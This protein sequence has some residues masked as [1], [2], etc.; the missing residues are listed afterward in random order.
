MK[1]IKANKADFLLTQLPQTRKDQFFFILKNRFWSIFLIGLLL[2]ISLLPIIVTVYFRN[3]F[4]VGFYSLFTS[5]EID[6]AEYDSSIFY[7]ILYSS[8]ICTVLLAV[9]AICLSGANRIFKQIVLGE[10]MIFW[11][12]FKIGIKQNYLNTFLILLFFGI[13]MTLVRFLST[14]FVQYFIGI[15]LYILL[16]IL[17]VPTFIVALIFTS[18]YEANVFQC[19]F[20]AV[21]LYIPYWWK[22]LL[23]SL[24]IM[25]VL[26]AL[27]FL[28]TM[29]LLLLFIHILLAL[30]ALPIYILILYEISAK[31]FD[32]YINKENF[33]DNYLKG[34]Y[35]P[36]REMIKDESKK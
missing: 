1:R 20:N 31:L 34:L 10:D 23:L 15:P 26:Y 4:E 17:V 24:F 8:A 13:M 22:Y 3:V 28:E 2:T 9:F 36:D 11:D 21:K 19:I 30:F 14:F 16:T 32:K 29:P 12:D 25:G 35:N 33:K 27:S 5:G 6:K 7:L 18:I